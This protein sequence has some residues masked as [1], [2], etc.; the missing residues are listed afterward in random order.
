MSAT[1]ALTRRRSVIWSGSRVSAAPPPP[2]T[3]RARVVALSQIAFTV[4]SCCMARRDG[5]V[6]QSN[7]RSRSRSRLCSAVWPAEMAS[8]LQSNPWSC[9]LLALTAAMCPHARLGILHRYCLCL[10]R[11]GW[12]VILV[13]LSG[14]CDVWAARVGG[15][16]LCVR[17][18]APAWPLAAWHSLLVASSSSEDE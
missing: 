1:S 16:P 4:V 3:S 8:L 11:G 17:A 13:L 2:P 12:G 15:N 9:C 14:A 6:T 5:F 18:R 7:P 10:C